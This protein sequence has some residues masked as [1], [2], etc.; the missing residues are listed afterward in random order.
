M[1]GGGD[2]GSGSGGASGT[3]GTGA[4]GEGGTA[5]GMAAQDPDCDFNGIWAAKQVTIS[6]ALSIPQSSNNWYYLEFKQT[7]SQVEVSE[8]FDCGIEIRGSFTVTVSRATLASLTM[9]NV[10]IGR[11]GTMS[12]EGG[13]CK[14]RMARFWS[15]RGADEQRFLPNA[16][17]DSADSS[18]QV[19]AAKPL[20]TLNMPDGAIDAENDGKLGVAFTVSDL[21]TRN[22]VQRDWTE[23]FTDEGYEITPSTDWPEELVVRADFDNEENVLDPSSG[24]LTTLSAPSTRAPHVLRLRF[25]GRNASDPRAS[26]INKADKVETCFAIQDMLPAE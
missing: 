16:S 17:R 24:L 22:S 9:R 8:H 11:S 14:F 21:G 15:I 26:A 25:L 12:K 1:S 4:G 6:E 7:G 18:D 23:W 19:A 13:T 20:P 3:S 10:Q 5:G 2:G